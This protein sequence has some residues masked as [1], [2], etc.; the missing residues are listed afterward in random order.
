[1]LG[2]A[3]GEEGG[4]LEGPVRGSCSKIVA[5]VQIP[6]PPPSQFTL[7]YFSLKVDGEMGEF[8]LILKYFH[9][10]SSIVMAV[11]NF[12]SSVTRSLF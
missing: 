5:R 7:E 4:G 8:W 3:N 10:L 11:D 9:L 2:K 12:R 1:M 6:L